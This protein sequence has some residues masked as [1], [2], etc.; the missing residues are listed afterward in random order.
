MWK[1]LNV[2]ILNLKSSILSFSHSNFKSF[3]DTK[4]SPLSPVSW[5]GRP[6]GGP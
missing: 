5:W 6:P 4:L 2:V 3:D 1:W